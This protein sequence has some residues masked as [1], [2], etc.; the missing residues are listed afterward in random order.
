[1]SGRSIHEQKTSS[2]VSRQDDS[3]RTD[4]ERELTSQ[5]FEKMRKEV[6]TL[7]AHCAAQLHVKTVQE[8]WTCCMG[9]EVAFVIVAF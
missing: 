5:D 6:D 7:G 9:L 4:H 2:R 8:L 1:M 3:R